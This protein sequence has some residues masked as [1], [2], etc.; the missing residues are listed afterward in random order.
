MTDSDSVYSTVDFT[1][2]VL[3]GPMIL[4]DGEADKPTAQESVVVQQASCGAQYGSHCRVGS[5]HFAI[6]TPSDA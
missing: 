2:K 5:R 4:G 6:K 3:T 1:L